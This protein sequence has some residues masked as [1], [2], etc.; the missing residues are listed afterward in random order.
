MVK[1]ALSVLAVAAMLA[2][3]M[4]STA[5]AAS[6]RFNGS[7]LDQHGAAINGTKARSS[8]LAMTDQSLLQIHNK[9]LIPVMVKFDYD[10]AAS[11][12]GGVAGY[13]A[14]SP[15]VTGKALRKNAKAV[16]RYTDYLAKREAAIVSAI[17]AKIPGA[18][19]LLSYR[20]AYGG[21]AMM[22][23][24]NQIK[25][26]LTVPGVDSVQKNDLRLSLTDNSPHFIGADLAWQELEGG[27]RG[28][29]SPSARSTPGSTRSTHPS[30]R[31][32]SRPRPADPTG[33]NS[34]TGPTPSS[35]T[36]SPATTSWSVPMPSW[37]AT[38]SST[39]SPPASTATPRPSSVRR[40][41]TTVTGR[42]RPRPQVASSWA[43][44]SCSASTA[45]PSAGS[46]P[47]RT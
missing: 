39:G 34:G 14:T 9:K 41:T 31:P 18:K 33:A 47:G 27:C 22:V 37:T 10:G 36:R 17:A 7:A 12:M 16:N 28:R 13:A 35:A 45:D 40:V 20:I 2:T 4:A 25:A 15:S 5:G 32:V 8:R 3:V 11:Y 21:V 24:G 19:V 43:A 26:I 1:R 38:A 29:T 6:P 23:P 42:T 30:T 44:P 46:R